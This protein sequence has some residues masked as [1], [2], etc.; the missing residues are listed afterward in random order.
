MRV[1]FALIMVP[2]CDAEICG[3]CSSLV[4]YFC[5]SC[6]EGASSVSSCCHTRTHLDHAMGHGAASFVVQYTLWRGAWTLFCW[7]TPG[8]HV[9]HMH[10]LQLLCIAALTRVMQDG[11]ISTFRAHCRAYRA[12][13]VLESQ[14]AALN[15][16]THAV[17]ARDRRQWLVTT[18]PQSCAR[19]NH[20]QWKPFCQGVL[21]GAG[22]KSLACTPDWGQF[23][24]WSSSVLSRKR[25]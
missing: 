20:E 5:I 2:A 14:M 16:D 19:L 23:C 15:R 7:R 10:A 21:F 22:Y 25:M 18:L 12:Q 24:T 1:G 17:I 8:A 3:S 6:S 9:S 4:L 13:P 11:D